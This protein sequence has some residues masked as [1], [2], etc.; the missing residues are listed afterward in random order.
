MLS[1][2]LRGI[3]RGLQAGEYFCSSVPGYKR[4][5]C[6]EVGGFGSRQGYQR[7]GAL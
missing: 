5:G 2:S 6:D 1:P 4:M 3:D 7:E